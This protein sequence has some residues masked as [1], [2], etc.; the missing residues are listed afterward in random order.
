MAR[1]NVY[2]R[3]DQPRERGTTYHQLATTPSMWGLQY[4]GEWV[5]ETKRPVY[6]NKPKDDIIKYVRCFY[7][8]RKT[9]EKI[10]DKYLLK[11]GMDCQVIKLNG[12]S[13][14]G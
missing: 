2:K 1:L 3:I 12:G 6:P 5:I 7:S 9:A 8:N 10:R 4:E 13:Q 11:Y 14:D